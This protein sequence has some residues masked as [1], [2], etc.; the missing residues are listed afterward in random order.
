MYELKDEYIRDYAIEPE[1]ITHKDSIALHK[2]SIT[3]ARRKQRQ[4]RKQFSFDAERSLTDDGDVPNST[5]ENQ[6]YT[7]C[8]VNS[9]L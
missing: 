9:D 7:F 1:F 2:D 6:V 3:S 5:I 8:S 4:L